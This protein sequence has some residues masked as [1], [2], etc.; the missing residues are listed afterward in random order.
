MN[1]I[2]RDYRMRVRE[3]ARQTAVFVLAFGLFGGLACSVKPATKSDSKNS[4]ETIS[5]EG[6]STVYPICQAFAVAFEKKTNHKVSVGRQGTGGG[7]TKFLNKQADIWNAS[8]PIAEKEIEQLKAKGIEWV[9]LN[10]AVD[11]IVIAV[12]SQNTWCKQLTCAQLKQIWEPES[13]IK[14]WKDLNP[15]WPAEMPTLDPAPVETQLP[16]RRSPPCA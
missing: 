1:L 8:R 5:A 2:T 12:N 7:F 10:I 9:E 3:I 6:S 14:T 16:H 4:S 11:G 13:K 15:D